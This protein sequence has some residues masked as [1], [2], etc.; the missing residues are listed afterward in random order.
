MFP[1]WFSC[2][3]KLKTLGK[4]ESETCSEEE[5]FRVDLSRRSNYFKSQE[6]QGYKWERKV[7]LWYGRDPSL[8]KLWFWD[9]QHRPYHGVGWKCEIPRGPDPMNQNLHPQVICVYTAVWEA[10]TERQQK[11][12]MGNH[13]AISG[14]WQMYPGPVGCVSVEHICWLALIDKRSS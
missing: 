4:R 5:R 13:R 8:L 3:A 1:R 2:A 9:Q 14:G 12:R 10:L 11:I 6:C 7:M